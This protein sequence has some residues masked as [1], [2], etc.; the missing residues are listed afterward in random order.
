MEPCRPPSCSLRLFS[1]RMEKGGRETSGRNEAGSFSGP[2]EQRWQQFAHKNTES[3]SKPCTRHPK[4][5]LGLG[6]PHDTHLHVVAIGTPFMTRYW[7]FCFS[8]FLFSFFFCLLSYCCACRDEVV[9][10][11]VSC[12]L[13]SSWEIHKLVF[14]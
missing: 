2:L 1:L 8:F 6:F 5:I 13:F 9:S 4:G 7:F 3:C 14:F 11:C 10:L 12:H